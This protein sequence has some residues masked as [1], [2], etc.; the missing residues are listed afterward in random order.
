MHY[1]GKTVLITGGSSGIGL[2]AAKM[3]S[4]LGANLAIF[5]RDK[6]KLRQALKQIEAK[7]ILDGQK[8]AC[9][10]LDVAVNEDVKKTMEQVV[11]DFGAPSILINS[12]GMGGSFY[13]ENVSY[14]TFDQTV[15]I[16]LYGTRNTIAALLP[17]MKMQGGHIVNI[18]SLGGLIGSF[19]Y[20]A[21]SASKFGVVGFSEC[22]RSELKRYNIIVSVLCPADVDTPMLAESQQ[23]SPPETRALSKSAGLMQPEEVAQTLLKG[24]QKGHSLIIPGWNPKFVYALNRLCPCLQ[25]FVMDLIVRKTQK[26]C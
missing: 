5:G 24:M 7:R 4:S 22:L 17:S 2:A 25:E 1:T 21:Y 15:K 9:F 11:S 12:A 3:F 14:E 6:K 26:N 20:S 23:A 18:S 8:F 16:N 13:F 19:G 10:Q